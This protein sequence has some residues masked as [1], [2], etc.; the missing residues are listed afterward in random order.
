MSSNCISVIFYS[1][2]AY[3]CYKL[4]DC[5]IYT[6]NYN[7]YPC[8]PKRKLHTACMTSHCSGSAPESHSMCCNIPASFSSKDFYGCT[9]CNY[10]NFVSVLLNEGSGHV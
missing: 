4:F 2:N 7:S 3:S 6:L 8:V 9:F 10:I 5:F 1:L